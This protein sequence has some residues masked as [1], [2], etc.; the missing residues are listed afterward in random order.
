MASLPPLPCTCYDYVEEMPYTTSICY[1]TK[2]PALNIIG[3]L[4]TSSFIRFIIYHFPQTLMHALISVNVWVIIKTPPPLLKKTH[5]YLYNI[6]TLTSTFW[7]KLHKLDNFRNNIC[8]VLP[9]SL[10]HSCI[11]TLTCN[12]TD[13]LILYVIYLHPLQGLISHE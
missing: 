11:K 5:S 12:I 3:V 8:L 6:T 2:I 7:I 9:I 13:T 4:W 1:L 10:Y